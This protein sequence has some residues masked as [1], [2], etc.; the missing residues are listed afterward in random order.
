KVA[1]TG[2]VVIGP[3][4][5]DRVLIGPGNPEIGRGAAQQFSAI[6][7]DRFGN[8]INDLGFFWS[9]SGGA[10][11]ID[12]S[13]LFTAGNS[14]ASFSNAIRAETTHGF[15]S[16]SATASVTVVPDRFAFHSNRVDDVYAVYVQTVPLSQPRAI[17]QAGA[18]NGKWSPDGRLVLYDTDTQLF[19]AG[20]D[21]RWRAPV[22]IAGLTARQGA[23]A[24]SQARIAFSGTGTGAPEIYTIAL[25]GS[26]VTRLTNNTT[27]DEFPTW[28]P[29]GTEIAFMSG[30]AGNP[31]IYK[32]GST[33]AS[34]S[35]LTNS[36]GLSGR[37][38][39]TAPA[40]GPGGSILFQS[41]RSAIVRSVYLMSSTGTGV[42]SLLSTS[43]PDEARCPAWTTDGLRFLYDVGTAFAAADI[44]IRDI[45]GGNL[46][47]LVSDPSDDR[48]PHWSPV[49]Q[50]VHITGL[51]VIVAGATPGVT[52]PQ[53]HITATARAA[54]VRL[55]TSGRQ[56]TGFVISPGNLI[57]TTNRFVLNA[58]AVTVRTWDGKTHTA[59]VVG[60]DMARD[61]ALLSLGSTVTLP[62]LALGEMGR[63]RSGD[64]LTATG[65]GAATTTSA[66]VT[67]TAPDEDA[68][69]NVLW[70]R[71]DGIFTTD[72]DGG[73]VLSPRGDV[74]GMVSLRFVST[75]AG[76]SGLAIGVNTLANYLDR[77]KA[78]QVIVK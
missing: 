33:G 39:D 20:E 64:T 61:V 44:V 60:R 28:N 29:A 9:V 54:T 53:E 47:S 4:V 13:G 50:G 66:M 30:V 25:D 22:S 45:A 5:L 6:G 74:V 1:G 36:P 76:G 71:T 48:C 78:G 8:R 67:Y 68:A 42:L 43:G 55:E 72:F 7:V 27:T 15:V 57:L 32:I 10:G 56:G 3:S 75:E 46:T 18:R 52:L 77:L 37:G 21:G 40:W 12:S 31:E 34:L 51:G 2:T 49:K 14:A 41:G 62:A 58:T 70:L 65:Y 38:E 11:A 19:I 23:W 73:P 24:P 17:S 69:R 63:L 26:G 59:T 35:R 16:A